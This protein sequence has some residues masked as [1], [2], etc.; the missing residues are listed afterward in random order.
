MLVPRLKK[1]AERISRGF[2]GWAVSPW[3]ETPSPPEHVQFP[4]I[5]CPRSLSPAHTG[6]GGA[7]CSEG[8]LCCACTHTSCASL[9]Q[10]AAPPSAI[11][12]SMIFSSQ[13][14]RCKPGRLSSLTRHAAGKRGARDSAR[15]PAEPLEPLCT[16]V[17]FGD[18]FL[19]TGTRGG[20][21]RETPLP[22]QSSPL[23][24]AGGRQGRGCLWVRK[25]GFSTCTGS[26]E[27]LCVTNTLFRR[28]LGTAARSSQQTKRASGAAPRRAPVTHIYMHRSAKDAFS[29]QCLISQTS[30]V[31]TS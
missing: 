27:C 9:L 16:C 17:A 10:A 7:P 1:K 15:R 20:G 19:G 2:Q 25:P 11:G 30:T 5:R 23:L 24:G 4:P 13:T 28:L 22:P 3:K 29:K 12:I 18:W 8:S 26:C 14:R 6:H 21:T 31:N